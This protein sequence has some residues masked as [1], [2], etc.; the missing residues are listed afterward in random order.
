LDK[1]WREGDMS[2]DLLDQEVYIKNVKRITEENAKSAKSIKE[3]Q[4]VWADGSA[5]KD[6]TLDSEVYRE[7]LIG[8]GEG[9]E[10][11]KDE[12][13]KYQEALERGD[14]YA[15]KNT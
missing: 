8:L 2:S 7:A 5:I 10:T 15:I 11:T 14:T 12:L 6:V 13:A 4:K 1:V 3:L 9:Y